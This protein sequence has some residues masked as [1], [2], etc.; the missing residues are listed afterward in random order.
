MHCPHARRRGNT[1]AVTLSF[2]KLDER[3]TFHQ[4][5]RGRI[6]V[7][8]ANSFDNKADVVTPKDAK[9]FR[10]KLKELE[11]AAKK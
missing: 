2:N 9:E 7:I 6:D 11:E 5:R 8:E 3:L 4:T 1:A 10:A